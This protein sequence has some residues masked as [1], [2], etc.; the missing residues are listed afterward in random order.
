MKN[1]LQKLHQFFSAL[2][3]KKALQKK[4]NT[5]VEA[6]A[7]MFPHPSQDGFMEEYE[8]AAFHNQA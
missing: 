3:G 2:I 8:I 4:R 5:G 1:I 7:I 6:D